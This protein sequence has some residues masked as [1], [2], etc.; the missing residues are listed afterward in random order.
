[1]LFSKKG[2]SKRIEDHLGEQEREWTGDP[3]I[4]AMHEIPFTDVVS[5]LLGT[6]PKKES[7]QP[8]TCPLKRVQV[9]C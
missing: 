9:K 3:E 5:I 6:E 7:K 4:P 8:M 2:M 1:M